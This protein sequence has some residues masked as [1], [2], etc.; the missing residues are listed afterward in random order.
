MDQ[1]VFIYGAVW[2]LYG[3][4]GTYVLGTQIR[5]RQLIWGIT[6]LLLGPVGMLAAL[7]I[8]AIQGR[9][10]QTTRTRW[11]ALGLTFGLLVISEVFVRSDGGQS[12]LL[13]AFMR[14]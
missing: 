4:M 1:A 8:P 9:I 7:V 5:G 3:A 10:P 6:G 2:W 14:Y 12:A 13:Y 11:T